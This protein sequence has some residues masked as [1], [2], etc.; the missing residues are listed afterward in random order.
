[1]KYDIF[2]SYRR[3][4]F[5]SAKGR[6]FRIFR[7]RDTTVRKVQRT[8]VNSHRAVQRFHHRSFGERFG[9]LQ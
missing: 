7:C 8:V 3:A 2:I 4:S 9:P 6:L 1:M 5:E